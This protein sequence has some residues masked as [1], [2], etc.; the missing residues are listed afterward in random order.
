[1]LGKYFSIYLI[2]AFVV[3]A[4]AHPGR[5]AYLRSAV[6][7]ALGRGRAGALVPHVHWLRRRARSRRS[8]TSMPHI[9]GFLAGG[10]ARRAS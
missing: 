4:L 8:T 6:A 2:A 1:M 7:V 9:Q 10:R 3:A 5:W